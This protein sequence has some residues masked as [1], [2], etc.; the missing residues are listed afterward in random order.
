MTE[1]AL[2]IRQAVHVLLN[3]VVL[4]AFQLDL[5]LPHFE[6]E[7]NTIFREASHTI[8]TLIQRLDE[9]ET[10]KMLATER[11]AELLTISDHAQQR[12]LELLGNLQA[13]RALD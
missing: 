8:S 4:A 3:D 10:S 11:S 9:L 1:Q 5:D 6:A 12:S 2:H 7:A 13:L